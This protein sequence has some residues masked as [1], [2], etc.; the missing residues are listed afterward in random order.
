MKCLR[1]TKIVQ[2]IEFGSVW[3]KL[4]GKNS[5]HRQALTKYLGLTQVFMTNSTLP[6][7]FNFRFSRV[8]PLIN[9]IFDL[10]ATLNS[11]LSFF[12]VLRLI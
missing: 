9:K 4:G 11:R 7:T 1:V 2:E 12:E 5:F 3:A 8:F 6:E 10:A